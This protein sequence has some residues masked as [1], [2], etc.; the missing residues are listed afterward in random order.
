MTR[1]N[2]L[3]LFLIL[4]GLI[5]LL[6]IILI[7]IP[8]LILL[9][10]FLQPF[11]K[12]YYRK[13]YKVQSTSDEVHRFFTAD[14][15]QISIYRN[16]PKQIK[17]NSLPIILCH[18]II[19]NHAF[20]DMD[21]KHSLA[22]YF[23]EQN[24]DV[25][26]V[27]LRGTHS[28]EHPSGNVDHSIDDHIADIR[29]IIDK[30]LEI[31][32]KK[33]IHWVGHSMGALILY[34]YLSICK[35]IESTKVKSFISLGGP[36]NLYT[37]HPT[38][39]KLG[40]K[41]LSLVKKI[42]IVKFIH[43]FLPL[44]NFLPKSFSEYSYTPQ[45][46]ERYSMKKMLYALE[47]IPESMIKQFLQ[48]VQL[49]GSIFSLDKKI[50]YS[51]RFSKINCPIYFISGNYDIVVPT[52]SLKFVFDKVSSKIKKFTLVSKENFSGN[53]GHPCLILGKNAHLEIFPL[54][55]D[56]IREVEQKKT[57]P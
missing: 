47:N 33:Q 37:I 14:G 39:A 2:N 25:F 40:L 12:R 48:S 53:Y 19:T 41:Y 22:N 7:F 38:L 10:L 31:S 26:T 15:F 27:S 23:E 35:P 30:V 54:L 43:L 52:H 11:L 6:L 29:L 28:S 46:T 42:D 49:G 32:G 57:R 34:C 45:M 50:N 1:F 44:I 51:D 18:G 56:F 21:K 4:T 9:L 5:I 16:K 20:M 55:S 8:A 3:H 13:K 36:G 17:K 24:Y